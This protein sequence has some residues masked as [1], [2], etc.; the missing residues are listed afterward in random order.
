MFAL[1]VAEEHG[2]TSA[3]VDEA[4]SSEVPEVARLLGLQDDFGEWMGLS[5]DWAYQAIRQVGSY[6]EI[7]DRHFGPDTQ[8]AM[9]RGLNDLW[10][11]GGLIYAPP[12]R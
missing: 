6:G 1:I 11:R 9:P 12:I 4:L 7:Y 10:T 5:R 8:L 2:I 3:N